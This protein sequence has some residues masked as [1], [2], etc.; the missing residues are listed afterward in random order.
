MRG[1]TAASA[2]RPR[3]A[4]AR[5]G[6]L[7]KHQLDLIFEKYVPVIFSTHFERR[8]QDP[9]KLSV[10]PQL[11][12]NR[13]AALHQLGHLTAALRDTRAALASDR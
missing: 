2:S 6:P 5:S 10:V 11:L 3:T 1:T 4:P 7:L 9:G 13:A 12:G 8:A